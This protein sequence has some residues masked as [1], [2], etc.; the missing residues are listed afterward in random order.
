LDL[1]H[2]LLGEAAP[3]IAEGQKAMALHSTSQNPMDGLGQDENMAKIYA[4]VGDA[5]HAVPILK[6][7]RQVPYVDPI[8]PDGCGS[9]HFGIRTG[10]ILVFR[11]WPRKR[12]RETE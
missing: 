4:L 6:R 8:T 7:L 3:A 5:D 10:T 11:N 2:A 1:A 12:N 9:T